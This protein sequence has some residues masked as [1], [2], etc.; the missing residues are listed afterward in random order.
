MQAS[1][2]L[3]SVHLPW[4]QNWDWQSALAEQVLFPIFFFD[5]NSYHKLTNILGNNIYIYNE[6]KVFYSWEN[7]LEDDVVNMFLTFFV[8]QGDL[9][10][11]FEEEHFERAY[12]ENF[13]EDMLN[14]CGF[15]LLDKFSGY[16]DEEV[17]SESERILYV[18]TKK[19]EV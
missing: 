8:K 1:P 2:S 3:P 5:I 10:E 16:K 6:E 14:K 15:E 11:R 13:I 9:Y 7:V 18:V 12:E 17:T 19:M 4:T